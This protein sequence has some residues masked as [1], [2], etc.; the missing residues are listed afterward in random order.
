MRIFKMIIV[1]IIFLVVF[2]AITI[3]LSFELFK[4]KKRNIGTFVFFAIALFCTVMFAYLLLT[5]Q[6]VPIDYNVPRYA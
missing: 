6:Y 2:L 3:S 1:G 5:N 4:K